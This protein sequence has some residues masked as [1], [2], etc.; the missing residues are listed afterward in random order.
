MKKLRKIFGEINLNWKKIIIFAIIA[1][2]YTAIIAMLPIAK[3]TSFSDLT[4]S[5]EVWILFGIIIIMN[6]KSAKDSAL[7]CFT[8]FLISQ[9]L[10]YLVQDAINHSSLFVTYYRN[11]IIWTIAT[12]PMGFFGYYM[13]KNKW[14]GLLILLPILVLLGLHFEIY[15]GQTIFSFPRHL[16]T[17]IFCIVTMIIYPL[18]IFENKKIRIA[19][20]LTGTLILTIFVALVFTKPTTY[21]TVILTNGGSAG[22]VFDNSYKVYL[23]D[24]SFGTVD[25]RLEPGLDDWVVHAIFKKTGNA[26]VTLESINGEKTTYEITVKNN[27]Y[28]INKKIKGGK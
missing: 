27:T 25:I 10:V 7:K 5:F 9:P 13:K 18:V 11:W 1:G 2:I 3:D 16:L 28:D 22:A 21:D 8:F 14:W 23:S 20:I 26:E 12:L 6:S 15:L 19:G 24:D 4:V 17:T